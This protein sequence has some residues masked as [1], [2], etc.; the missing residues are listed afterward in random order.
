MLLSCKSHAIAVDYGKKKSETESGEAEEGV[1][2]TP[3][4]TPDSSAESSD[5]ENGGSN[6]GLTRRQRKKILG[7]EEEEHAKKI[8]FTK[9]QKQIEELVHKH[10]SLQ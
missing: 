4:E 2:E 10:N 9:Y 8:A 1:I 6:E 3:Q 7:R 5:C